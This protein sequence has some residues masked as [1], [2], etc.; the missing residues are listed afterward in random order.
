MADKGLCKSSL[1][2]K[3]KQVP[4]SRFTGIKW[5]ASF[6][7]ISLSKAPGPSLFIIVY[8][9]SIKQYKNEYVSGLMESSML[10]SAGA[11]YGIYHANLCHA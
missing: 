10:W 9:S 1:S 11:I 3:F 5:K 4:I 2:S 6:R 7:S 8:A